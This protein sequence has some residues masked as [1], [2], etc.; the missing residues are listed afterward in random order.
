MLEVNGISKRFGM[1]Q[2]LT[3]VSFRV[4]NGDIMGFLGPNGAGKTT[5]I[6]IMLGLLRA[7]RGTVRI[8]GFDTVTEHDRAIARVGAIVE[9]PFFYEYLTGRENLMQFA[10]IYGVSAD[11]VAAVA[12]TVRLSERL[13]EKVKGYSLGMKQRLGVAQAL[14]NSPDVLILDEPTNGLDPAGIK[15]LRDILRS[16]A[17]SGCAV[18]VSSHQLSEM[19]MMCTR[20]CIIDRGVVTAVKSV[21]ELT[22]SE[23][24]GETKYRFEVSD[25]AA[26]LTEI[27]KYCE[28]AYIDGGHIFASLSKRQ[29]AEINRALIS[30]GIDVY[31]LTAV[32]TTLEDA[33]LRITHSPS[34]QIT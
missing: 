32:Q 10:R 13:D 5:C 11:R 9:S 14:L 4:E 17:L 20:V 8:N 30:A 15:E 22:S 27:Q 12:D 24:D 3:G 6:K 33:Y 31:A 1:K 25:V 21:D 7:D 16:C 23:P 18:L 2:V 26:A 19:Q 29:A 34:Q 28:D